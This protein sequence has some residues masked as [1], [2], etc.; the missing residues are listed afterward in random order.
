LEQGRATVENLIRAGMLERVPPNLPAARSL[1]DVAETH[2]ASALTLAETDTVLAYDALH[3]A[4][5]KA[6]TAILLAQGLRPTRAGGHIA[7]YDAVHAQLEPPLGRDLA[8]YHRVRRARNAGDYREEHDAVADDVRADHP[9]CQ[10]IVD[11][12]ERVIGQM[13]PF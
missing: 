7:V 4:N 12:A 11:I 8:A 3:G 9:G 10:K 6:L 13:P 1:V 2:L 5:R